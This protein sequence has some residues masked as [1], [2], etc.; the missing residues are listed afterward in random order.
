VL[1]LGLPFLPQK[2]LDV[3]D[4]V[5]LAA[6]PRQLSGWVG[7]DSP[8]SPKEELYFKLYGGAA[9][10]RQYG[11]Y[12]LLLVATE[13]PLRHLHGPDVCLR[14]AGHK[15]TY[16]GNRR[17][18]LAE[19]EIPSALY[20]SV[21]P[22]GQAWRVDVTYLSDRGHL[23]ANIAEVTWRW[24]QEPERRWTMVQRIAPWSASERQRQNWEFAALR[25]LDLPPSSLHR[26]G[27]YV[28]ISTNP[29][30]ALREF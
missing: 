3:S 9:V 12:S 6:L 8:L 14:G 23:S 22:Q 5:A 21:D 11:P 15:V 24:L 25:A 26:P 16:L 27:L 1:A 19:Q 29:I 18:T 28:P 30:L 17:I 2:P 4:P 10:R 7:Q 13:T 20:R